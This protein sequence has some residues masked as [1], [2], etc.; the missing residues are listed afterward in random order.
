M[1]YGQQA[2]FAIAFQ[3]ESDVVS[4]SGFHFLPIISES[5]AAERSPVAER[6]MRGYLEEGPYHEGALRVAGELE[7]EAEPIRL[8]WLLKAFC[9]Y[10]QPNTAIRESAYEHQFSPRKQDFD[11]RKANP[12]LTFYKQLWADQRPQYFYDLVGSEL[13]LSIANGEFLKLRAS[14]IGGGYLVGEPISASYTPSRPW[15]W[16]QASCQ[17]ANREQGDISQLS[18]KIEE[19]LQETHSL[20]GGAH[21]GY[22]KRSGHRTISI[23]GSMYLN[24]QN[25]YTAFLEGKERSWEVRFQGKELVSEQNSLSAVHERLR[26]HVPKFRYTEFKP[27]I[28]G[29]G[30]LEARFRA[31]AIP[32]DDQPTLNITLVNTQTSY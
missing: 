7:L 5:I 1:T 8:G 26:L 22:V 9:A 28:T 3:N 19:N 29:P 18:L 14:F 10:T 23:E 16:Q 6:G 15:N 11:I 31:V 17:I 25:E 4:P 30:V 2:K 13:E 12:P 21:P 27:L 24:Q 20:G 32:S